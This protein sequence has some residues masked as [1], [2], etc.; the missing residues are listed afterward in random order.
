MQITDELRVLVEAEVERAVRN[1]EQFDRAVDS[2]ERKTAGFGEALTKLERNALLMSGAMAAAGIAGVKFAGEN[3]KLKA[4]LEVL[5][6]SAEQ[7][8]SVFEE[9]KQFGAATPL[10]VEEIGSAGKALLA[11]GIEAEEVTGTMRRLGDVAQGTGSRLGDIADIYGKARVQGRLFTEDINQFQGRGIPIVQALAKELGATEGEIKAMVAAGKIGFPELEQ[12]FVSLTSNGGRFEG[13]MEKLSTTTM[14]K[15]ST[16]TDNA[17]QALASF[18]ELMLPLINDALDFAS[19]AF[20]AV[21]EMDDGTKRFILGMGSVIAIS[22]PAITAIKGLHGA[23]TL[24]GSNPYVLGITAAIAGVGLLT[25]YLAKQ[26]GAAQDLAEEYQKTRG[27]ADALLASYER[28]NPQKALDQATTEK[29]IALY[30]DL[31]E[32][33]TEYGTTVDAVREKL[34]KYNLEKA[35]ENLAPQ[36]KQLQ[37]LMDA[38]GD[39]QRDLAAARQEEAD[40]AAYIAENAGANMEVNKRSTQ[41]AV[42]FTLQKIR[43]AETAFRESLA[44]ANE[45]AALYGLQIN[46]DLSVIEIPP[47][48]LAIAAPDETATAAAAKR[49]WQEWYSEITRIDLGS[50]DGLAGQGAIAAEQYLSGFERSLAANKTVT[51]GLGV[52]PDLAGMLR[53]QQGEIRKALT[54]LMDIDPAN[55][56][57]PFKLMDESVAP[58][59]QKFRDIGAAIRDLDHAGTVAALRKEIDDLGRAESRLAS[60]AAI[61]AGASA[62][63]AEEIRTLMDEY[64]RKEILVEYNRRVQELGM[65][66]EELARATLVAKGATEEELRAFDEMVEKLGEADPGKTF[67]EM[68]TGGVEAALEKLGW[69]GKEADKVL[70]DLSYQFASVSMDATLT[71]LEEIG[72]ALARN[73]DAGEAMKS[74]LAAMSLQ[75]LDALP[76]MF[77]QAGL[78]LIA[79]PGMWPLGLGLIA[80]AGMTSLIGGYVKGSIEQEREQA[81]ANA[82]GNIF[83]EALVRAYAKGGAFTNRIVNGPTY[84]RHGGGLGLM[85]EAGP[86][87]VIPLKRMGNG[88]L[89]VSAQ[90]GGGAVVTVNIINN[91]GAEV[92]RREQEDQ[93]GNKQ[94]DVII[95]RMIDDHLSSGR[96]DKALSARYGV[97]AQG[98]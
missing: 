79:T 52:E 51:A 95:G 15:L 1:I 26:R 63:Q 23:F 3:E 29:L 70:A 72:A 8:E 68:F 56:D 27:A 71:G 90:G 65:S 35:K 36:L 83:D 89:G 19:A 42:G 12:A 69:F 5:L 46:E 6:G 20:E 32:E 73:A 78:Q 10:S 85:G 13:M 55:I 9:W 17:G 31:R 75:I 16:A 82:Q 94:I 33:L 7:A 2:S 91:S 64:D 60:D 11:F 53:S 24:L 62:E 59:V 37:S 38:W 74:A 41:E 81:E 43:E 88:D 48:T 58:L 66:Q 22:G 34:E 77:L 92:S 96:A 28:A 40:L 30:P 87:A 93:Y 50:F 61:A 98:V 54:E 39:Y 57:D 49:R 4:S 45:A 14:G 86:E 97:R 76:G 84:F 80:A 47:V 21:T 18:G 25:G 44:R 67:Q